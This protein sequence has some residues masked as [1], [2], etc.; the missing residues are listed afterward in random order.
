MRQCIRCGCGSDSR[1]CPECGQ[2][3]NMPRM[4]IKEFF[5]SICA[6]NGEFIYT[7]WNLLMRPW[8]VIREYIHGR[9]S[10]YMSPWDMLGAVVFIGSLIASLF[11]QPVKDHIPSTSPET[12]SM[13][14]DLFNS[15][16]TYLDEN[17]I[18]EEMIMPLPALLVM[19]AVFWKYGAKKYNT[20]EYLTA[21]LYIAC[22]SNIF[23]MLTSP[24]EY[25]GYEDLQFGLSLSYVLVISAISSFKVFSFKSKVQRVLIYLLFLFLSAVAYIALFGLLNYMGLT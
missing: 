4:T 22:A 2:E 1:F 20:V 8:K 24:I 13:A 16:L 23:D 15:V 11:G 3:M 12:Q 21:M 7:L 25:I 6:I 18:L 14:E 5:S 10:D 19:I 17:D 9:R